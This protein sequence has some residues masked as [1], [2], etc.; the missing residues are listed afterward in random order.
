M[1]LGASAAPSDLEKLE[2][3]WRALI[4]SLVNSGSLEMLV[5]ISVKARV[6]AAM[7]KVKWMMRGKVNQGNSNVFSFHQ[8]SFF[9]GLLPEGAT[10]T[11]GSFHIS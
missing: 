1:R 5:L 4:L 7:G 9:S 6:E 8:V 10:H 2:G 11:C 3:P